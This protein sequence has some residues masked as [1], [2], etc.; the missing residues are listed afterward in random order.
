RKRVP[1]SWLL[2]FGAEGDGGAGLELEG[3]AAGQVLEHDLGVG[4]F[5]VPAVFDGE[6]D[7]ASGEKRRHGERTVGIALVSLVERHVA[8]RILGN[9][10]NHGSGDWLSVFEGDAGKRAVGF[11]G[12]HDDVD[13]LARG[14]FDGAARDGGA[15]GFE[16]ADV[17]AAL[18]REF[19]FV[20]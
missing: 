12:V 7:V 10:K 6:E 19:H 3:L 15:G 5:E 4:P 9:E 1:E 13:G 20:E 2:D 8:A 17:E 14:N 11:W 16:R 18:R